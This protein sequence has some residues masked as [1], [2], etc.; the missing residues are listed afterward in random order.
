MLIREIIAFETSKDMN[1][2]ARKAIN[3]D[4]LEV[5]VKANEV[6]RDI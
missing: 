5:T 4:D 3:F 2:W 6:F 1:M